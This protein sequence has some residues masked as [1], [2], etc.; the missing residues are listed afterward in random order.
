MK[1]GSQI[2]VGFIANIKTENANKKARFLFPDK[3]SFRII[4]ENKIAGKSGLGD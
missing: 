1:I 3:I 4:K 2:T